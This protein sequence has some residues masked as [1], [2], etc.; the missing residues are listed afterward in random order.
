MTSGNNL[1]F[2]ESQMNHPDYI[3]AKYS[4]LKD[5]KAGGRKYKLGLIAV[6][7]DVMIRM[8]FAVMLLMNEMAVL[9]V[10]F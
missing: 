8:M 5:E 7:D 1:F 3:K 4:S 10:M 9:F 2:R 6:T